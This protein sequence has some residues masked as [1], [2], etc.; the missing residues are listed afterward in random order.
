M[1][2]CES[3]FSSRTTITTTFTD[4]VSTKPI[5]IVLNNIKMTLRLENNITAALAAKA[6]AAEL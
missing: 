5:V 6:I 3:Q 1:E 2:S 4:L